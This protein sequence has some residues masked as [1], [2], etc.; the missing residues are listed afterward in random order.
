M[1]VHW[2]QKQPSRR[3]LRKTCNKNIQLI[4][5]RTHMLKCDFN[6][7]AKLQSFNK[8]T[9]QHWC[10]SRNLL[11]IF[12]TPFYKNTS[13][14]LLL[15]VFKLGKH[16]KYL[17]DWVYLSIYFYDS[18]R[19]IWR[20]LLN[21]TTWK[22]SVLGDFWSLFSHIRTQ[23]GDLLRKSPYSVWMRENTDQKNSE[24]GHFL[25]SAR[26]VNFRP[27]LPSNTRKYRKI[28]FLVIWMAIEN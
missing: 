25:R 11:H 17:F 16:K 6:K 8:L 9:P 21:Y 12:R 14:W 5:R 3:V 26:L 28:C 10:F 18:L 13:G 24:Y 2:I 19:E 4:Y 23:Y 22:V 7:V 27:M 15:W 1:V 20:N